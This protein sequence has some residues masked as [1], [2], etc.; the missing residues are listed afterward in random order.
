MKR[1]IL[2]VS[3]LCPDCPPAIKMAEKSGL[4]ISILDITESMRN[5]KI[6]LKYRDSCHY[7]DDIKKNGSVGVPTF[8]VGDG[9]EFFSFS[10]DLDLKEKLK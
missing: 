4:K 6:F 3:S 5:L 10:D 1:A 2:F 9:E 8:M 7:F